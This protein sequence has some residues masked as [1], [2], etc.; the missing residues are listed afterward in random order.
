M[1]VQP[2][3]TKNRNTT[4]LATVEKADALGCPLRMGAWRS[5]T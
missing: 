1:Y 4:E 2:T 3:A 5:A